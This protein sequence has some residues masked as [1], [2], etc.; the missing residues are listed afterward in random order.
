MSGDDITRQAMTESAQN[1]FKRLLRDVVAPEL[2]RQV[3]MNLTVTD[4]GYWNEH[5]RNHSP[6][7][8]TPPPGVTRPGQG[9][10]SER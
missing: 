8:D 4:K 2:R 3:T 10:A 6:L 5:R 7:K 1:A 9:G